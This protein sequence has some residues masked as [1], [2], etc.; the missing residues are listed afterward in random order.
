[1]INIDD[2][3]KCE[4]KIGTILEVSVVEGADKLLNLKIDLG[5]A[6]VSEEGVETK[7]V[8]QILSGIREYFENID[9]LVG[10]QVPVLVNLAPRTI[11][12]FD[13]EGMVLYAVGDKE[14]FTTMN[15]FKK[16]KNGTQIK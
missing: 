6:S 8:R 16:V 3:A 10:L 9:E 15:P 2:F 13:S 12:G 11:R 5:E 7:K 14:N 4:I 1:M